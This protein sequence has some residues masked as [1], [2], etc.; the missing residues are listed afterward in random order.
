[1]NNFDNNI[2]DSD[3]E[4]NH[5]LDDNDP[6]F[7]DFKENI[8]IW[9]K[10]DDDI[11]TLNQAIKERK[12]KKKEI[13]PGLLEFMEKHDINDLN[14]N[15]GHLKFQK[16]LRSKPLSKKYLMDKLG[17]FFKSELK[18]EKVVS[19]IYNN[20]DKTEINNLKRVFPRR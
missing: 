16:T 7:I 6:D 8:K 12:N 11:N 1:M 20:C 3:N 15:E 4:D 19:F 9:L 17:F 5:Y 13:T 14:T 10:I 2:D 18:G